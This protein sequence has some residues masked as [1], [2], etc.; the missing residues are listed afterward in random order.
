MVAGADD[1]TKW[2]TYSVTA[3]SAATAAPAIGTTTPAAVTKAYALAPGSIGCTVN[4][5]GAVTA[6][7]AGGDKRCRIQLTLS[8]DSYDNT[9]HTYIISATPGTIAATATTPIMEPWR[10]GRR[11]PLRQ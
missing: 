2:G 3:H 7:D 1:A 10:W 5:A 11:L 8:A 6:T 9:V 4:S